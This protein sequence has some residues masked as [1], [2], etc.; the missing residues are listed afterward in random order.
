MLSENVH[1][2][3][4][5]SSVQDGQLGNGD[6]GSTVPEDD[7]EWHGNGRPR[8]H[9]AIPTHIQNYFPVVYLAGFQLPSLYCRQKATLP[10]ILDILYLKF[11]AA[12][13]GF[14]S[15]LSPTIIA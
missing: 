4:A 11:W 5:R 2:I 14:N 7:Q 6:H 12:T 13:K 1:S 10:N 15:F 9:Q 3:N 8:M